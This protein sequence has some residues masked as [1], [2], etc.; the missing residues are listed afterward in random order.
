MKV[1]IE[2][3]QNEMNKKKLNITQ[4][5]EISGI[6]KSTISRFMSG[7]RVCSVQTAQKIALALDLSCCAG[8]PSL[9]YAFGILTNENKN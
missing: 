6:D 1:D 5:S 4:L 3:L 9:D 2:L 7:E 8:N